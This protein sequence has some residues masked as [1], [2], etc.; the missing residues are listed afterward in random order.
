MRKCEYCGVGLGENVPKKQR[1]CSQICYNFWREEHPTGVCD[2]GPWAG[3]PEEPLY[4]S[5]YKGPTP[6][7]RVLRK[8]AFGEQD[9]EKWAEEQAADIERRMHS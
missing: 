6:D 2:H 5:R 3:W 9:G 7:V 4:R 1:F 8:D